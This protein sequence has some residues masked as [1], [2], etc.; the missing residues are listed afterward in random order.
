MLFRTLGKFIMTKFME[1]YS[2]TGTTFLF[3]FPVSFI[4]IPLIITV[5]VLTVVALTL[6]GVR[7]IAIWKISEE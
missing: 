7:N 4:L 2:V 3:E 1:N 6:R 5:S